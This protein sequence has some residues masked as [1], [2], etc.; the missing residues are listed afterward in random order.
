MLHAQKKSEDN[1]DI[2]GEVGF[3][4]NPNVEKLTGVALLDEKKIGTVHIALGDNSDM[5][6]DNE[7]SIHCDMVSELPTVLVDGKIIIEKSSKK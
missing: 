5:G 2:L 1:W 6:G 7:S 3:G 4:V